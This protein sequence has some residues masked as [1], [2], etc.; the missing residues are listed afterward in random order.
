MNKVSI[1]ESLSIPKIVNQNMEEK[2]IQK[3]RY[4]YERILKLR[5]D[6]FKMILTNYSELPLKYIINGFANVILS[7]LLVAIYTVIPMHDIIKSP[8]YWYETLL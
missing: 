8:N 7:L 4:E 5:M 2:E 3:E 6:N 1:S